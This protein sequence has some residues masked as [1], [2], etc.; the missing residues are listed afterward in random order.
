MILKKL[1]QLG[2]IIGPDQFVKKECSFI[3]PGS[4]D[5]FKF[6]IFVKLEMSAADYEFINVESAGHD[7]RHLMA[8][9]IHRMVRVLDGDG[10]DDTAL[11]RIPFETASRFALPLQVAMCL[12]INEAERDLGKSAPDQEKKKAPTSRRKTNSGASSSLQA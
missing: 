9:R 8:R 1:E 11:V 12:C 10:S 4:D 3:P 7:D 6:D 2:A 5:A